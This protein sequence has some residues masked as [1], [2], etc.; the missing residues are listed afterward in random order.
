MPFRGRGRKHFFREQRFCKNSNCCDGHRKIVRGRAPTREG[1]HASKLLLSR[2]TI[3]IDTNF[4]AA[5]PSYEIAMLKFVRQDGNICSHRET[6]SV[7]LSALSSVTIC[8]VRNRFAERDPR[9]RDFRA[10]LNSL[11]PR[12]KLNTIMAYLMADGHMMHGSKF[13]DPMT[14]GSC[15]AFIAIQ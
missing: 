1:R 5:K 12:L 10:T 3:C 4:V 11:I 2:P 6:Q 13:N 8:C 15:D 9:I 7:G 14:H